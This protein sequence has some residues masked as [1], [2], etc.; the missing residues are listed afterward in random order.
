MLNLALLKHQNWRESNRTLLKY[1]LKVRF[2]IVT[3]RTFLNNIVHLVF[4]R[5][6]SAVLSNKRFKGVK[7]ISVM[8][9]KDRHFGS[10]S[11][12]TFYFRFIFPDKAYRGYN[13]GVSQLVLK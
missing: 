9:K 10:S 6:C 12:L 7:T 3:M 8:V 5:F 4:V 11:K 1:I 2:C 13:I